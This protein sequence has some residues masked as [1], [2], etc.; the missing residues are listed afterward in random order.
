MA[1]RLKTHTDYDFSHVEELQRVVSRAVTRSATRRSRITSLAMGAL[2]LLLAVLL[3]VQGS[4]W[5]LL[6]AAG[7]VALFFLA[8]AAFYYPFVTFGV[9]QGMDKKVTGSD[10]LL[11]KSW[12]QVTNAKGSNQYPYEKC[13]RLLETEKNLYFILKS[14]QGLILDKTNLKGGTPE[15]LRAWM[16]EKCGKR[17]EWM[18]NARGSGN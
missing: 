17:A 15:E 13:H 11:E 1:Q 3:A 10:Y 5:I 6:G 8:R 7:G 16:E 18:G 12:M 2:M 14:G 9:L 4:H